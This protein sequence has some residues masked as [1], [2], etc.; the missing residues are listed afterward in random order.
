M[1]VL[2]ITRD[3]PPQ[4]RGGISTVVGGLVRTSAR[5]RIDPAVISFDDWRPRAR[6]AVYAR[7]RPR[8][9]PQGDVPVFRVSSP[10][11]LEAARTVARSWQ[12]AIL[13]VHHGMLWAFA[14]GLRTTLGI[15]AVKT[16]HVLQ[17]EVGRLRGSSERTLSLAGQEAALATADRVIVPSRA[18][19]AML[20]ADA[21]DI[22]DRV[23][24]V[25]H[26]IEDSRQAQIATA[27]RGRGKP[28]PLLYVGRFAD[29]KGT[30][31]FLA[32]VPSVLERR[33]ETRVVIAGGIP[34]NVKAEA[35]WLSQWRQQAPEHIRAR[36]AFTGWIDAADL[37]HQ[38]AA[39]SV[40]AVPSHV[41]TFGL[42]A[43]EGMLHG[44]PIVAADAPALRELI[45]DGESG[46]L[47]PRGDSRALATAIVTLLDA[48]A[49]ARTLGASAAASVRQRRLWEHMLPAVRQV[50][51]ELG[52][53]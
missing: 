31:D 19:A 5:A 52:E 38:Y 41:E 12:P 8:Q 39:A 2:H 49:R 11:D 3:F 40:L 32:A 21:P 51:A 18:T 53:V 7:V 50:Y 35:R 37:G 14:A 34:G 10:D 44:T 20:L 28:G 43:L 6:R 23:R 25:P 13:H 15:P 9:A 48:P 33:P 24:T 26:G 17:K 46:I 30:A 16:I 1:R 22:H 47:Y 4:H 45:I 42:V 27:D 36:V 29:I